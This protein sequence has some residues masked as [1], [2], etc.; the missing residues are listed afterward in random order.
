MV[1]PSSETTTRP[2]GRCKSGHRRCSTCTDP[3]SSRRW[4]NVLSTSL[5]VIQPSHSP[6][7]RPRKISPCPRCRGWSSARCTSERA[8]SGSTLLEALISGNIFPELPTIDGHSTGEKIMSSRT[9]S[10]TRESFVGECL[11]THHP[12]LAGRILVRWERRVRRDARALAPDTAW[13]RD[14][15]DR[16][17]ARAAPLELTRARRHRRHRWLRPAPRRLADQRGD[18]CTEER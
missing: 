10:G 16:S 1:W 9:V 12:T 3:I 7:S 18:D 4:P 6:L 17:R 2:R 13:P 14:P 8:N 5:A 11:D 15:A